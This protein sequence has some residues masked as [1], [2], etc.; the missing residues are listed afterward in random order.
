MT[1]PECMPN[2]AKTSCPMIP[3]DTV[4]VYQYCLP[5]GEAGK[6]FLVAMYQQM[7]QQFNFG[8][9]VADMRICWKGMA[10]M[11]AVTLLI[12]VVYIFLL[13]WITKPLLYISIVLILALF[14]LFGG[15]CWVK[16]TDYDPEKEKKN[17]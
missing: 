10:I 17:Y 3:Y 8:T 4:P 6:Q 1:T 14:M 15:W 9:Y 16:R 13:R 11:C 7:D 5:S 2:S 12:A